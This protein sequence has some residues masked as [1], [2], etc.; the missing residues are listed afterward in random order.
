MVLACRSMITKNFIKN[1]TA[2]RELF[3]SKDLPQTDLDKYQALLRENASPVP[4]I[5][6]S[7]R[8]LPHHLPIPPAPTL[9]HDAAHPCLASIPE[10]EPS[11]SLR[12]RL[13]KELA[14]VRVELARYT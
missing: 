3:F 13:T 1:A 10:Q 7:P 12:E 9:Q 11:S 6:V 4:V 5:D 2:C 8:S 14:P